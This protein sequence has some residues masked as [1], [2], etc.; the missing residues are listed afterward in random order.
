M[1]R[2]T[3]PALPRMLRFDPLGNNEAEFEHGTTRFK[4]P[5]TL[6]AGQL[7]LMTI[8]GTEVPSASLASDAR[9]ERLWQW[10]NE[11]DGRW[12]RLFEVSSSRSVGG[13][14][15]ANHELFV[16]DATDS[17]G[18]MLRFEE[19]PRSPSWHGMS[20]LLT[21][22]RRHLQSLPTGPPYGRLSGC[23]QNLRVLR[24]GLLADA[25]F[26]IA[27]G[28]ASRAYAELTSSL[29]LLNGLFEDQLGLRLE[30]RYLVVSSGHAGSFAQDGPDGGNGARPRQADPGRLTT[31]PGE[32]PQVLDTGPSYLL[33]RFSQWVG[34]H[35]PTSRGR[36]GL[37]FMVTD[38]FPPPGVVGLAPLR[39]ACTLGSA[40]V[41]YEVTGSVAPAGYLPR[42][43]D[44]GRVVRLRVRQPPVPF[45]S[46][47]GGRDGCVANSA[48]CT[49][50]AGLS[51]R[52]Q[53]LWLTMAH[54]IGHTLGATHTFDIGGRMSY[55]TDVPFAHKGS[56]HHEI[57]AFISS[58]VEEGAASSQEG[59]FELASSACGNGNL[60]S[61]EECDDGNTDGGDG[62]D[63][64]CR[65]ECGWRCVQQSPS[66]AVSSLLSVCS[67]HC[68]DGIVQPEMGEECDSS[69]AC[70]D[71]NT[72]RLVAGALCAAGECCDVA[73]CQLKPAAAA[74]AGGDGFCSDRG[75]CERDWQLGL[76][77]YTVS[78]QAA[79]VDTTAC[80]VT[81]CEFRFVLRPSPPPPTI[82]APPSPPPSAD[83][84]WAYTAAPFLLPDGFPC[85]SPPGSSYSG[86]AANGRCQGGV[87]AAAATCGDGIVGIGEECDDSSACCVGCRFASGG[88]CSPPGPCCQSSC[89]PRASPAGCN[90]GKGYCDGGRCVTSAHACS[91]YGNLRLNLTTCP[92]SA[93]QPCTV[94]C[95]VEPWSS[96][97]D[98]AALAAAALAHC[99][100]RELPAQCYA[101]TT[102]SDGAPCSMRDANGQP[103][104]GSCV[105]GVC[106]RRAI[107]QQCPSPPPAPAD[108]PRPPPSPPPSPPLAP[109]LPPSQP[110][111]PLPPA[112]TGG[113]A[114]PPNSPSPP[115]A[116]PPQVVVA[117]PPNFGSGGQPSPP[118]EGSSS[119]SSSPS[120]AS[121]IACAPP[122]PNTWG[123]GPA[124]P[125]AT[126]TNE[127]IG[128]GG[129][130]VLS[131][132]NA[133]AA[134]L[135]RWL[136]QAVL[137]TPPFSSS[138]LWMPRWQV[139]CIVM[140]ASLVLWALE[141][142]CRLAWLRWVSS[143]KTS[144]CMP[145]GRG[146][147]LF[148]SPIPVVRRR[149]TTDPSSDADP[150]AATERS[151]PLSPPSAGRVRAGA[152]TGNGDGPAE[153]GDGT[154]A[155]SGLSSGRAPMRSSNQ[156]TTAAPQAW[157]ALSAAHPPT[158]AFASAAAASTQMANTGGDYDEDG[159]E[160]SDAASSDGAARSQE[161]RISEDDEVRMAVAAVT[162]MAEAEELQQHE[163]SGQEAMQ[164]LETIVQ[165]GFSA[166]AATSALAASGGRLQHALD[167]LVSAGDGG[168]TPDEE[169]D[170][171]LSI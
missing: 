151:A 91:A 160:A 15:Y 57:C 30:A 74:C 117:P 162:A 123:S 16:L 21:A 122:P 134:R 147:R 44:T 124:D 132:N 49:A 108:P 154:I 38:A 47:S 127:G 156:E 37:W 169:A 83:T 104:E 12:A 86:G 36:A 131:T 5:L 96:H 51:S 40:E 137:A 133:W 145:S 1:G 87:C 149:A 29:H 28:G 4:F 113:Y 142:A 33:G 35:A 23:P 71:Q 14:I 102:L 126:D 106:A 170:L 161:Q 144:G 6:G 77:R 118:P 50:A 107:S 150:F 140:G 135:T 84:C 128:T 89:L 55:G 73:T 171:P 119:S 81:G 7:P 34:A 52:S 109:P 157:H 17:H 101:M 76:G 143:G 78:G 116:P 64:G 136:R 8:N 18:R 79:V 13:L 70:C 61:G 148:A 92:I 72:C 45:T 9:G 32:T 80:P 88:T 41:S 48:R 130:G 62:C 121:G 99:R 100:P 82:S 167:L 129:G 163:R 59:C 53:N 65:V 24:L 97:E 58:K 66:A 56:P 54:E 164:H 111:P 75:V 115:G 2:L 139:L 152:C 25:G 22:H 67:R 60:E 90:D 153:G 42:T 11:S 98:S 31:P 93:S 166:G 68:G 155:A 120:G 69:S 3:G 43:A 138:D 105:A 141:R 46:T 112:P 63:V 158:Y 110:P 146:A 159:G 94:F 10:R 168:A 95:A 165:M 103:T 125:N 39:A 114:P 26:T 19:L 27:A 20:A 85:H